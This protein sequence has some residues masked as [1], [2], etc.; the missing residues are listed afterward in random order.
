MSNQTEQARSMP[1]APKWNEERKRGQMK[2]YLTLTVTLVVGIW[3]A[4]IYWVIVS[5]TPAKGIPIEGNSLLIILAPVLAAAT[6]VERTLESFF[7]VI[8][9]TFKT[10]VAYLGR[11]LR[12]LKNSE[13]EVQQA[14]QWLADVSTRFSEEMQGLE[15]TG[16]SVKEL[17]GEAQAKMMAA[18]AMMQLAQQRLQAAED[19]LADVTSSDGYRGIKAAASIVLGLMLGVIVA[20]LG[21]LQ[22]FALMGVTAVPTKIDIFITGLVI[23][24][25]AYPVHSLVGILQQGK[26][27]LD[28]VKGFFNRSAPTVQQRVTA[29]LPASQSPTSQPAVIETTAKSV[30]DSPNP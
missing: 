27:T 6:G 8:E 28:S 13:I 17:T 9:N 21:A 1:G 15:I 10:M 22:M 26:D 11:G 18:N 20:Q 7:N 3:V 2:F 4:I 30:E 24:S 23:G 25:G 19:N 14:R 5:Q 29:M 16:R 12:W